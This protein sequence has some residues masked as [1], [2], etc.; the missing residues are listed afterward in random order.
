[1]KSAKKM[2]KGIWSKPDIRILKSQYSNKSTE[3]V[4][5]TLGRPHI[6][7]QK[8]ASRLGLCKTKS[9]LRSLGWGTFTKGRG[10]D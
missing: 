4:A 3:D 10:S 6:A 8:K 1:M 5:V 9:Y 7:V 2:K